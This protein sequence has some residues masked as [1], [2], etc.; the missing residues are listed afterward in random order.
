MAN[1]RVTARLIP[2]MTSLLVASSV[3]PAPSMSA[4]SH[5]RHV[6]IVHATHRTVVE[7]LGDVFDS[8][9]APVRTRFSFV[10]HANLV[11]RPASQPSSLPIPD[12]PSTRLRRPWGAKSDAE[13]F[14]RARRHARYVG[15]PDVFKPPLATA[16]P[17]R[18]LRAARRRIGTRLI[19][20]RQ[21]EQR[22]RQQTG[23]E[24][25]TSGQTE[26]RDRAHRRDCS[27]LEEV[28]QLADEP[29]RTRAFG[30]PHRRCL[31]FALAMGARTR[32]AIAWATFR[33]SAMD[34]INTHPTIEF[35]REKRCLAP[36][37]FDRRS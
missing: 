7:K 1:K 11:E 2:T 28:V 27:Q 6:E 22:R 18:I 8:S 10:R 37:V 34:L 23:S 4:S 14:E 25:A 32:R 15:T 3:S 13:R 36:E 21:K 12:G 35:V 29:Q 5:R 20:S 26:P 9:L 19:A 24:T 33:S 30:R 31:H 17:R 16:L